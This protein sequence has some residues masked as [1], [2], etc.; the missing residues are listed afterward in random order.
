MELQ[1]SRAH[2]RAPFIHKVS[3]IPSSATRPLKLWATNLS[4]GGVCL[5]TAHPF[6]RGDR[7]GLRLDCGGT[8]IAIP[9]CEVAWVLREMKGSSRAPGVGLRFL[10]VRPDDRKLIRQ[11]VRDLLKSPPDVSVP[12][13][14]ETAATPIH[15]KEPE[16]MHHEPS[17][18]PPGD[19][20]SITPSLSGL[21][22]TAPPSEISEVGAAGPSLSLGPLP[23]EEVRWEFSDGGR[24]EERRS[25]RPRQGGNSLGLAA[26]LL[27]AGTLTGM[28]FGVLNQSGRN[29]PKPA[30]P[31]PAAPAAPV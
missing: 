16:P 18:P 2:V 25:V 3:V 17:L 24:T 21:P 8:D 10:D 11:T 23:A 19:P 9:V 27:V 4:E 31:A 13:P 12:P 28:I 14:D 20:I 15:S 30:E 22:E 5:Q 1:E 6:R 29:A 7:I 26:G